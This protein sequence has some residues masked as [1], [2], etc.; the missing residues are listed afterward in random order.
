MTFLQKFNVFALFLS[1]K[2]LYDTCTLELPEHLVKGGQ[3]QFL[4]NLS[5]LITMFYYL[6]EV[7]VMVVRAPKPRILDYFHNLCY[8]VEFTV[9]VTYWC[10]VYYWPHLLNG[11]FDVNWLVDLEIH[12]FPFI[13]LSVSRSGYFKVQK[14]I[15]YISVFLYLVSYW[16]AIERVYAG[17]PVF[18]YP[19]LSQENFY[20]RLK[21]LMGFIGTTFFHIYLV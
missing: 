7:V 8:N 15:I 21:W 6:T 2:G 5:I 3:F 14:S 11:D 10:L 16:A 18:P 12:L 1:A 4:T 20:G 9:T 17:E 13:L 19:F